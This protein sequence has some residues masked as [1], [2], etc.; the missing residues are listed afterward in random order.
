MDP[1][2]HPL[3]RT[4]QSEAAP[5]KEITFWG[6]VHKGRDWAVFVW[7]MVSRLDSPQAWLKALWMGIGALLMLVPKSVRC[8]LLRLG[9]IAE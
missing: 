7:Q 4:A 8:A 1:A 3:G 9:V 5:A 6:E 2:R